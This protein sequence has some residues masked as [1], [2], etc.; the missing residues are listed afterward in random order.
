[1]C[2]AMPYQ[3]IEAYA[4]HLSVAD[5]D[6]KYSILLIVLSIGFSGFDLSCIGW[7]APIEILLVATAFK[8]EIEPLQLFG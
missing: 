1:M 5:D 7:G 4:W 2:S 3:I 6:C 8:V